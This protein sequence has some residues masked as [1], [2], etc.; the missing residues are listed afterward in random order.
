MRAATYIVGDAE[1]AQRVSDGAHDDF[2]FR[3]FTGYA[4]WVAGRGPLS[5]R[6][7]ARV[8]GRS[9]GLAAAAGWVGS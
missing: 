3:M 9:S 5:E 4:G 6:L 8:R 1:C 7:S 2:R